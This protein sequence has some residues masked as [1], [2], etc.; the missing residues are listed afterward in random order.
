MDISLP[1]AVDHVNDSDQELNRLGLL[2]APNSNDKYSQLMRRE[3]YVS[4][5]NIHLH[6]GLYFCDKCTILVQKCLI[7]NHG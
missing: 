6:M 2:N 7:I 4:K 3:I 1:D 5:I